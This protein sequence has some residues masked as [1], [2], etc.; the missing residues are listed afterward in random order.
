MITRHETLNEGHYA[1]VAE[2]QVH[3]RITQERRGLGGFGYD[4]LFFHPE[5]DCTFGEIAA[6]T[7]NQWSHRAVALKKVRTLLERAASVECAE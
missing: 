5:S 7:K 4:C 1:W 3:G 6:A 2:G